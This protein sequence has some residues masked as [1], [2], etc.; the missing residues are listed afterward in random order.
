MVSYICITSQSC[1]PN[2]RSWGY[3]ETT[4]FLADQI[5]S[6]YMSPN[7]RGD[8]VGG[9]GAAGSQPRR[10]AVHNANKLWRSNSIFNLCLRVSDS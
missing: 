10:T 5:A 3:K 9:G 2:L 6:S 8:V 1:S 4:S 7:G